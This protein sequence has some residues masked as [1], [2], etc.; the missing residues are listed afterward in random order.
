VIHLHLQARLLARAY[1]RLE[2]RPRKVMTAIVVAAFCVSV[3]T[4]AATPLSRATQDSAYWPG[5]AWRTSAPEAQGMDSAVLA[6]ALE[7]VR[8]QRTRI[9]S[10]TLVRNG[11][12]VLDTTFFPFQNN[13][14]HDVAS[15]TK[16]I[17]STLIGIAIGEGR[18]RGVTQPVLSVFD[19]RRVQHRDERKQ[20]LTLE[21]LLTMTSGLDCE[22]SGGERTLREMRASPD[23]VQFMLDRPMIA[24]PGAKGEY[25]SAGMHLLS[26]VVTRATG[27]SA[28]EYA[29]RRLFQPLGISD[30]AW[31]A[32]PRGITHG[33]GDLHLR[34]QDMAKIG[35]LWLQGGRWKDQQIVPSAW[36]DAA[37]QPHAH[38]LQGDYGYGLWVNRQRE[39]ILFEA[40]GRGG[41]R[42]SVLPAKNLVVAITGGAFEPGEI[43]AFILKSIRSDAALPENPAATRRLAQG[44]AAAS[45]PPPSQAATSLPSISREISGRR[46]ALDDNLLGW[47]AVTFDFARPDT[48]VAQLELVDGRV[49]KRPVGLDAVPRLSPDG[50][51]GL[52]V[53]VQGSW[54]DASTFMFDYDE[55]ANINSFLCR[56][57]FDAGSAT[58]HVQERSGEADLTI[59]A[60]GSK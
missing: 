12:V 53:A 23:W 1:R 58:V 49:E 33:W 15:V 41:Q 20:Q 57:V 9:H 36:M 55:V 54:T 52:P 4:I 43:G 28:F 48:A 2:D 13:S 18:L 6:D 29:R 39:P 8:S 35:Y 40:N 22:Y 26:G 24:A 27:A 51:F 21:H 34:P 5:A 11:Y 3:I 30:V 19:D 60:T 38:V 17:T 14:P 25:C 42:I 46:Y 10:L 31:P 44:V 56:F 45:A 59:R 50:R 47:R 16:S 37:I 32:D 7:Y